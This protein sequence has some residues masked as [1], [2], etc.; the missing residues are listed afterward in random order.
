MP[1]ANTVENGVT[2]EFNDGTELEVRR[3]V[4]RAG[5]DWMYACKYLNIDEDGEIDFDT[6]TIRE[7]AVKYVRAPEVAAPNESDQALRVYSTDGEV[8]TGEG[9]QGFFLPEEI[10]DFEEEPEQPATPR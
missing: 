3:V 4:R 6:F 1:S 2:V 9:W 10:E 7:G 8:L 5:A